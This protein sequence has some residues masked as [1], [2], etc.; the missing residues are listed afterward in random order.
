MNS[1]TSFNTISLFQEE[2]SACAA[3]HTCYVMDACGCVQI[4]IFF[5]LYDACRTN[6]AD[7]QWTETLSN[8]SNFWCQ[9]VVVITT[10]YSGVVV[11]TTA[12]LHLNKLELRFCAGSNPAH[13]MLEICDGED[14]WQWS[15]LEIRLKRLSPVNHT[16]KTIHHHHTDQVLTSCFWRGKRI[17]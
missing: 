11:I 1:I 4:I 12:Q 2:I 6:K 9:G 16:T 7:C 3:I 13:R 5:A 8:L 14:L 10:E 15:W 17:Q